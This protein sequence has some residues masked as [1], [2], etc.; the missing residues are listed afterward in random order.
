MSSR[1]DRDLL[2]K[3]IRE[4]IETLC[5]HF[6]PNG[7]K[8]GSE[9]QTGNLQGEPGRTLNI[10]LNGDNPGI[11]QD[12]ATGEH[13]DF[14]MAV[15]LARGLSFVDAAR[16]IGNAVGVSV[17]I[18]AG[19]SNSHGSAGSTKRTGPRYTTAKSSKPCNWEKD[20]QLAQADLDELVAWRGLSA[21]FC[22]WLSEHRLIGRRAGL[23]AFPLH[24]NGA[25]VSAH[26]RHSKNKWFFTPRPQDIGV[27]LTPLVIGD[28]ENAEKVFSSESQWDLFSVLDKLGIQ[29]G[30]RI[31]GI[32]TRGAQNG[33][34]I[35]S[36]EIK[37]ELYLIPQNDAAGQAWLE[38]A[39][40]AASCMIKVLSV[41]SAYHDADDWLHGLK[42]IAEFVEAIRVARIREPNKPKTKAER[43]EILS[44]AAI[45]GS[46][47]LDVQIPPKEIIV[48]D[49]LKEGEVGFVYAYRGTGK[50]WFILSLCIAIA[51]G[52]ALGPWNVPVSHSVLY[53]DG[54]MAHDDDQKRIIALCGK[55]PEKLCV[56]NHEV[57][58]H[59]GAM[60][61]N[62]A[63]RTQQE[64]LLDLC[65]ARKIKVLVLDNLS[66][67]F[68]GVDEN[69]ASE[70]EKVKPWLLEFRRQGISPVVVHHTGYDQSRM[71]GTS[72]RED[73]ASWVLR[74]DNK[75]DDLGQ[76]GANFI[77]R[78]TKY[79]G[80]LG[81]S[82]YEWVFD[83]AGGSIKVTY[84]MASREEI[85]LQWVRDGLVRCEDIAREIGISKGRASQ[86]AAKLIKLGKLR[87]KGRE[88]EAV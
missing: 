31:A 26:E 77:S 53:V 14:I 8:A 1:I 6:F 5:L 82:D 40:G 15:K 88:Y 50:T 47:F 72:S 30:E 41:P 29:Y 66:C 4:N 61:M 9:W 79:R 3:I 51:E 2:K 87:K 75:K 17:D 43:L 71:R 76:P 27:E 73:A 39:A 16:E 52:T 57:L 32:A 7:K 37:A 59:Q 24:C 33:A 13:G 36:V 34:L 20:Y 19:A 85:F 21:S 54:E 38:H 62:L 58:F 49:Y 74:L 65:L 35:N 28:L 64:D 55:I 69:D 11:F 67:L 18:G 23:W 22:N 80:K 83:E 86:I 10:C 60:V 68:S 42:D 81:V 46:K 25:V 44:L 63:N 70:W 78:F 48:E 45:S 12:F 56:L 84:K